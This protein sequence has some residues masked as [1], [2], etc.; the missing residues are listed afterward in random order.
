LF[1]QLIKKKNDLEER[2]PLFIKQG[3]F[4]KETFVYKEGEKE[5]KKL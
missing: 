3:G 4:I 5:K 1:N 2:I